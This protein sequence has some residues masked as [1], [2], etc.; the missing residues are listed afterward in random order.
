MDVGYGIHDVVAHRS[1]VRRW[2]DSLLPELNPDETL[3]IYSMFRGYI[4]P[5]H[6]AY[7]PDL[8]AFVARFPH[9]EYVHTSGHATTDTLAAVCRTIPPRTAIIPIHRDKGSDFASLN[10]GDELR[11]KIVTASQTIDGI[12]FLVK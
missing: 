6:E 7:N 12:D 5:T 2:A 9:F 8:A 11:S 4:L 3:L 10:I 1:Q